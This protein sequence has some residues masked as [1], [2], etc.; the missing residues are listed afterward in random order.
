M[1][2]SEPVRFATNDGSQVG[3][4]SLTERAAKEATRHRR[5]VTRANPVFRTT[6][7]DEAPGTGYASGGYELVKRRAEDRRG[8]DIGMPLRE[9]PE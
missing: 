8:V 3:R 5:R 4:E 9:R 1:G 7:F 6:G 2:A